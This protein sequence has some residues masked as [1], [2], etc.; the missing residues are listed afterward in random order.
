MGEPTDSSPRKCSPR[1]QRLE[2]PAVLETASVKLEGRF[3]SIEGGGESQPHQKQ[4][5]GQRAAPERPDHNA[6]APRGQ[7][8]K[9]EQLPP[10]ALLRCHGRILSPGSAWRGLEDLP[11]ILP[12]AE[13][14]ALSLPPAAANT[15]AQKDQRG[16]KHL[17][18]GYMQIPS[19]AK[20]AEGLIITDCAQWGAQTCS[21]LPGKRWLTSTCLH[22]C[23]R[24]SPSEICLG[25][26]AHASPSLRWPLGAEADKLTHG[27]SPELCTSPTAPAGRPLLPPQQP[28]S[29]TCNASPRLRCTQRQGHPHHPLALLPTPTPWPPAQW[30]PS[31][32]PQFLPSLPLLLVQREANWTSGRR[33]KHCILGYS[34]G[35]CP[36][37][38]L[39][40]R[41]SVS[42]GQSV[43]GVRTAM[44]RATGLS[45]RLPRWPTARILSLPPPA[46]E[47]SAQQPED[48]RKQ[49][50]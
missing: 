31:Q 49:G 47:A 6:P 41:T 17:L 20:Q 26:H 43:G 7:I 50:G 35:T 46:R 19:S 34:N 36:F 24:V 33:Q 14:T 15:K 2:T 4:T 23:P 10:P 1:F 16:T 5:P 9:D 22:T 39:S 30:L 32:R 25:F 44:G 3:P 11:S 42:K 40:P 37:P 21:P 27:A 8:N 18:R 28:G 38:L 13:A 45:E 12:G 29:P 48:K